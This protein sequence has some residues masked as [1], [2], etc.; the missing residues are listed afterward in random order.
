MKEKKVIK[1]V[2][3]AQGLIDGTKKYVLHLFVTDSSPNSVQAVVNIKTICR[4][5]LKNRY[6]LEIIDIYQQP[7]LASSEEIIV[8][9]LLIKKLP[10]PQEKMIG[11]LS[12]TKMVLKGLNLI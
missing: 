3:N 2:A 7:E 6:K 8:I 5:Y 11:D 10:L 1:R 4:K 12:D 9:P